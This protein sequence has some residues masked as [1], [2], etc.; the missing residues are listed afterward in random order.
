M[1]YQ[2]RGT[3]AGNS[4]DRELL[5]LSFIFLGLRYCTIEVQCLISNVWRYAATAKDIT[6][7]IVED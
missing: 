6:P 5:F 2:T 1:K 7:E 4:D 3:A